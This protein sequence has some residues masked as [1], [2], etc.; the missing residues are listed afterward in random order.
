MSKVDLKTIADWVGH[1][2]LELIAKIY[3]HLSDQHKI[4]QAATV[5]FD[6]AA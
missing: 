5:R 6:A 3:S 1:E 4:E 2:D